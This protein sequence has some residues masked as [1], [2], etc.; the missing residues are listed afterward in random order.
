MDSVL[1]LLQS[2]EKLV[3]IFSNIPFFLQ[4]LVWLIK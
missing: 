1:I 3:I 4:S 2:T